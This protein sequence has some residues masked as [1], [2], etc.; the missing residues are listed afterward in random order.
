MMMTGVVMFD[1]LVDEGTNLKMTMM[2]DLHD[3]VN[4]TNA[5]SVPSESRPRHR[6]H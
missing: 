6:F 3:L 1:M 4:L 5:T 2:E